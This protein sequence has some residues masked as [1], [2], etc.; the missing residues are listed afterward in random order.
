MIERFETNQRMSQAVKHNGTVYL[1]GQVATGDSVAAQTQGCL[2][3]IDA[4]LAKAGSSKENILQAVIWLADMGDFA[5]M[6]GVWDA[7]VK[8]EIIIT[9]ACD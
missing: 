9:A 8:V 4:L 7:W 1:A 2:D 5:E 3:Q 6:N